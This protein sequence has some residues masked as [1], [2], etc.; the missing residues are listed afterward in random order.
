[1][2]GWPVCLS[3]GGTSF[4]YCWKDMRLSILK[5]SQGEEAEEGCEVIEVKEE[6]NQGKR[7]S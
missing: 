5:K 1:M 4:G 2:W 7:F 3:R 6:K